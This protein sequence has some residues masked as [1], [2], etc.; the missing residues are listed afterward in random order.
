MN[1]AYAFIGFGE[2]GSALAIPG[3]CAYDRLTDQLHARAAKQTD[4][5]A[6]SIVGRESAAAAVRDA[7]V[8]LCLVT[9]DQALPAAVQAA[10]LLKPGALWLDMNSVAPQTKRNSARAVEAFGGRYV[11]VAV[12]APVHP[13]RRATPLLLAGPQ[14]EEAARR[15]EDAG[16]SNAR[17]IEG[18][19]GSASAI[20]MIRSVLVKGIEALTAECILAADAAGVSEMVIASLDGSAER[21]GWAAR[22]D[23]NLDRMM[24]HG[25]RRAAEME[26]VAKT[27]EALGVSPHM[28][29]GAIMRQR[30]IGTIGV[31]TPPTG[32]KAKL[33]MLRSNE[34]ACKT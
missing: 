20:K 6:A 1:S 21:E 30:E 23:Y 16:F 7:D 27:L 25:L 28:T 4:Y 29:R 22:S 8:V 33:T 34:Q 11:D 18:G 13:R 31:K 15:L 2:A 19:I 17:A 32:L 14:A 9:A 5:A 3:A 10:P 12:M 24:V 26:E